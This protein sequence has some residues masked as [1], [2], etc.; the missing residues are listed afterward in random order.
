MMAEV[1]IDLQVL[2]VGANQP[3]FVKKE[4]RCSGSL[5]NICTPMCEGYGGRYAPFATR[6]FPT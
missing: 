4:S 5:A 6:R 3:T 2:C 1:G